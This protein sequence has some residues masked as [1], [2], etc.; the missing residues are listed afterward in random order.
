MFRHFLAGLK[1]PKP[2]VGWQHEHEDGNQDGG[3]GVADVGEVSPIGGPLEEIPPA[4]DE[5]GFPE[6]PEE[7][8]EGEA[9]EDGPLVAGGRSHRL[10]V[11][12]HRVSDLLVTFH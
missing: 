8:E 4:E 12:L 10:V 9:G 5:D 3:S 6:E 1:R 7:E 2:V 11:T